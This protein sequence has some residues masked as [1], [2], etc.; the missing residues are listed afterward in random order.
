MAI[1]D[2]LY[3]GKLVRLAAP[4]PDRDAETESKWTRDADYLRLLGPSPARPLA[5]MQ[6]KKQHEEA[7]KEKDRFHFAIR[8]VADD[9]LVGFI[10]FQYLEWANRVGTLA[11]GIG[12]AQDRN[13]GYGT[14]ALQLVMRYAFAELNFHRLTAITSDYNQGALR[15]FQRA[16]FAV[17]V[18]RRQAIHRDGRRWD[19]IIL[20]L[21]QQ[22]W[23]AGRKDI[24]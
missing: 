8:A 3:Q 12:N 22:E 11:L 17:E 4:D 9:R 7:W 20:G 21:L 15:F 18:R 6:I 14:E 19:V 16:G 13:Q 1:N 24:G 5:P 23:N 10:K 2:S